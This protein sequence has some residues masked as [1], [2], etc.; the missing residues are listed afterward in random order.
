MLQRSAHLVY[1]NAL[2]RRVARSQ[3]QADEPAGGGASDQVNVTAQE[4]GVRRL[5]PRQQDR[6]QHSPAKTDRQMFG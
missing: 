4:H 3:Q 5:Q 1:L 2:V 6:R